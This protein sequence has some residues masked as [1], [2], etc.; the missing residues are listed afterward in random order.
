[1]AERVTAD[2]P[3]VRLRRARME[4]WRLIADGPVGPQSELLDP[5]RPVW[6]YEEE[7]PN[8]GIAVECHWRYARWSDGSTHLWRERAKRPSTG[9][10]SSGVRWDLIDSG[11]PP[12]P[13]RV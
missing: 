7:V 8:T 12:L 13:S 2:R 9:N 4:S 11:S 1:V 5:S 6:L 3:D 10:R